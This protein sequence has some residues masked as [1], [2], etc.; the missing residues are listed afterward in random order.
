MNTRGGFTNGASMESS[1]YDGRSLSEFGDVVIVS[2]DHRLN[3]LGTLD[4]SA[5]GSQYTLSRY[6]GT[7]DL[8][9]ALQSIAIRRCCRAS[10]CC[11]ETRG[12]GARRDPARGARWVRVLGRCP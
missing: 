6:T 7:T 10:V 8:V 3:I 11:S 4:L 12:S 2:V 5:Y 1:A 9:V